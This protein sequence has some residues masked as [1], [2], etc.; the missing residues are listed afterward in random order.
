MLTWLQIRWVTLPNRGHHYEMHSYA[1]LFPD[2]ADWPK[3]Q[4][5]GYA[6]TFPGVKSTFNDKVKQYD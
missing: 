2:V 5:P 3:V 6:F 1:I 4:W